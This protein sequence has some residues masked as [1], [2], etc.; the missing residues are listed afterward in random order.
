MHWYSHSPSLVDH[1]GSSSTL[2]HLCGPHNSGIDFDEE[3][4]GYQNLSR[5]THENSNVVTQ[6]NN[7]LISIVLPVYNGQRYLA[8]SIESCLKQSYSNWEL[9]LV[10]DG[11]TDRTQE[12]IESIHDPRVV[13]VRH[14][15]NRRLPAALNSGFR[16]S[17]GELLTWTSCDNR[18]EP[19]NALETMMRFLQTDLEC[20][21]VYASCDFIDAIGNYCGKCQR[22]SIDGLLASNVIGTLFCIGGE[23]IRCS[24]T[25]I[26]TP[27]L[28][29]I[30][31][32][33][34]V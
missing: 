26:W 20:D 4:V 22:N 25:I 11:S 27:V 5:Q 15:T 30:M 16:Q 6:C 13:T 3:F 9:I 8:E 33:G 2:G 24:V 1:I 17:Q 32:T 21:M 31:S 19:L 7:P 18:Y 29:K 10:D 23:S 12:I 28:S 34:C 14:S